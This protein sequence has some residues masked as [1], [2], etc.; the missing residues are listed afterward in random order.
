MLH[1]DVTTPITIV[2]LALRSGAAKVPVQ[3]PNDPKLKGVDLGLQ[4]F[5]VGK[6]GFEA[7]NGLVWYL[8]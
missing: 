2:P 8:D 1:I 5:A 6:Q 4:I 7:S 3:L